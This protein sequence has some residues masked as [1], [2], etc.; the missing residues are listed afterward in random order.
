ML[1]GMPTAVP[2]PNGKQAILVQPS[3][4]KVPNGWQMATIKVF[5]SD[6]AISDAQS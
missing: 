6:E 5:G 3:Y 4:R 1:P 2:R